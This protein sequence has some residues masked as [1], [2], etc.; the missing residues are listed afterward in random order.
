M[1]EPNITRKNRSKNLKDVFPGSIS[2]GNFQLIE[3]ID[4]CRANLFAV[5]TCGPQAELGGYLDPELS[6]F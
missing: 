3:L 5:L 1:L 6:W 4:L 2:L